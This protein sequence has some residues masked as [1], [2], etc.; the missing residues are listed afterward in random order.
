MIKNGILLAPSFSGAY[1]SEENRD[2]FVRNMNMVRAAGG[3]Q[4]ISGRQASMCR[5]RTPVHYSH[6]TVGKDDLWF[7]QLMRTFYKSQGE[8]LPATRRTFTLCSYG[9]SNAIKYSEGNGK[10]G[11]V[12]L[13]FT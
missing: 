12:N 1:V 3:N 9:L 6:V 7:I 4:A 10:M 13:S 2:G 11:R 8:S 5:N